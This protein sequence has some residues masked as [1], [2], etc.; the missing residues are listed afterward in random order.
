[1]TRPATADASPALSGAAL[2]ILNAQGPAAQDACS[3]S[4]GLEESGI[5]N[6]T[7]EL[8]LVVGASGALGRPAVR[9][10]R[11]RGLPVRALCRHPQPAADLAALGAEM[12]AGDLID[13][14]SL[15]HAC[16]G[17]TRVLACAH[18]LLGRGRWRSEAVDDAGHR[19]LITAARAAGVRR[20]VYTSA[21][22]ASE[23]SPIDFMRTKHSIEQAV[24]ES[25]LDAV[26]LRPSAFM[27]H[28]VHNF[29]G[30][31]VLT[32]GKAKLIGPGTKP[33]NF[34]CAEDVAR[35]AVLGLLED[36]P[37]FRTLDIG[38]PGHHTD[39][40]VA[41]MYAR[42]A[43]IDLRRSHLPRGVAGVMARLARPLHPGMA[44]VLQLMSL[45]DEAFNER[46]DGAAAVA[47]AYGVTLTR[48]EDFV[49]AK[50]RQARA[51]G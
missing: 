5:V 42:E 12:A 13:P 7:H 41:E 33:R 2:T 51:T 49:K 16:K 43:C 47:Q 48:L 1:M 50:V 44:R 30:L 11:E 22:G 28:H 32:Q 40:E 37:P 19:T 25:G 24:L 17:A 21:L 8:V 26:I 38:G 20:F 29:N 34:V 6:T 10:L 46:L 15:E 31:N 4:S 23:A 36:P 45:P 14:A 9:L 27:E 35:F 18:A 3:N 39:L